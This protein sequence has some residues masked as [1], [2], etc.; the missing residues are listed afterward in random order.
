MAEF[1]FSFDKARSFG[2][3]VTINLDIVSVISL[4]NGISISFLSL[5]LS[6]RFL[7]FNCF[8]LQVE[9]ESF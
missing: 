9:I 5:L 7:F 4:L 3:E 6:L 1:K 8:L 2:T